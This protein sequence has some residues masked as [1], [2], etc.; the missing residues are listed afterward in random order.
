MPASYD[1]NSAALYREN[2]DGT[3]TLLT[4]DV[5]GEQGSALATSPTAYPNTI[6]TLDTNSDDYFDPGENVGAS[7]GLSGVYEGY[8]EIN[9]DTYLVITN[10]AS[11]D[12]VYV[13]SEVEISNE[14]YPVGFS[15]SDLITDPLLECF[16]AGTLIATPQGECAVERLAIGDMVQ[17]ADGR[18]VAVKWI[19]RQIVSRLFTAPERFAPVRITAG[20]L[21]AGLPHADLL[22]SGDHAMVVDGLAINASALVNGGSIRWEPVAGLGERMTYYH[23][24]TEAHDVILANG[25]PAESYIDYVG[26]QAFDNY[27]EYLALYGEDRRITEMALPRVSSARLVPAAIRARLDRA[28]QDLRVPMQAAG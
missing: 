19:G 4:G 23:V 18:A 5:S 28:G 17:T 7:G 13:V 26:R 11:P 14:D 21:G 8:M 1:I 6:E 22:V 12:T 3:Y 27:A 20:A 16:T 10:T 25:A 2:G 15:D 24:E 9:G